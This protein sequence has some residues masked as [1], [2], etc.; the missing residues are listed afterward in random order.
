MRPSDETD[1]QTDRNNSS[2]S[3]QW[4]AFLRPLLLHFDAMANDC[5]SLI[6]GPNLEMIDTLP[7]RR[8]PFLSHGNNRIVAEDE[9]NL[10]HI[11]DSEHPLF[12]C[13][14]RSSVWTCQPNSVNLCAVGRWKEGGLTVRHAMSLFLGLGTQ[15]SAHQVSHEHG[16]TARR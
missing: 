4:V 10:R 6:F 1:S 2:S 15:H 12:C 5:H 9:P 14:S 8:D 16:R 3:C 11:L 13:T 7:R